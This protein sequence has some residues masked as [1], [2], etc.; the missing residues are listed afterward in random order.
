MMWFKCT[1][2]V[3]NP[4]RQITIRSL[5]GTG[6][7]STATV[8]YERDGN[9]AIITLCHPAARNAIDAQMTE[10]LAEAFDRF[11]AD[12]DVRVGVLCGSGGTFSAGTD[13]K[14]ADVVQHLADARTSA[15]ARAGGCRTHF[16]K[17]MV[18]GIGGYCVGSGLE[19][20]LLCDLRVVEEEACLGFFNRRY[21][22]PLTKAASAS[23]LVALIGMSRALDLLLTGRVLGGKEALD[24]GVAN[25]LV[26]TGTG[27]FVHHV[28]KILFV[29]KIL[30]MRYSSRAGG[31]ISQVDCQI[32]ASLVAVRSRGDHPIGS[33]RDRHRRAV[34]RC[35]S[36]GNAARN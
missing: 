35:N 8:H 33:I 16:A 22:V 1:R 11:E 27:T 6:S 10:R 25:R 21:G 7:T 29:S 2:T 17:P 12:P 34:Q 23:R 19:L 32:S 5:S 9:L 26:A 24:L 3:F 18:C 31:H 13:M 15:T 36:G 28:C 20:A 14:G 30:F 4:L